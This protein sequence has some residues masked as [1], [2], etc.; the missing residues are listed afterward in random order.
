MN[1]LM[2]KLKTQVE[3]HISVGES[4]ELYSGY[5]LFAATGTNCPVTVLYRPMLCLVLQGSKEV[6]VGE[7]VFKY[8][9][10]DY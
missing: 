1:E 8:S 10:G 9:P 7:R 2:Q 5:S 6:T 4:V 3:K